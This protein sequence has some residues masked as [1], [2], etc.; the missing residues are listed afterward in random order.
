MAT[1]SAVAKNGGTATIAYPTG[2][3][4][5]TCAPVYA[6]LLINLTSPRYFNGAAAVE[7]LDTDGI[8]VVNNGGVAGTIVVG[9]VKL[10]AA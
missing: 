4:K 5:D 2:Y 6:F 1:A 3:S 7:Y 10:A 9:L 8:H